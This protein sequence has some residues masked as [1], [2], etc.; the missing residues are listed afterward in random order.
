MTINSNKKTTAMTRVGTKVD[1][2]WETE[3]FDDSESE[4]MVLSVCVMKEE[5]EEEEKKRKGVY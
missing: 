1:R 2:N 4:A 5:E 3:V